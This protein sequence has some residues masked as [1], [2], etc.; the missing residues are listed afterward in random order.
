MYYG[1]VSF[2]IHIIFK[3]TLVAFHFFQT[4]M[5]GRR[6]VRMNVSGA[7]NLCIFSGPV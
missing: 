7:T 6:C 4:C 2:S 1:V 5:R 3:D